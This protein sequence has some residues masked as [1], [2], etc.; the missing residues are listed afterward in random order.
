MPFVPF[1]PFVAILTAI[2]AIAAP[3]PIFAHQ[4]EDAPATGVEIGTLFGLSRFSQGPTTII[5]VPGSLLPLQGIPSLYISWFPSEQLAIGPE[6]SFGVLNIDYDGFDESVSSSVS[7]LYLG[8]RGAFFLKSNAESSPYLLVNGALLAISDKSNSHHSFAAG[9][10]LGHQWRLGPA[11]V[12]RM[13]G[14]YRRWSAETDE[15]NFENE[16]SLLLGLGIRLGGK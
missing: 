5:G 1:V 8:G 12:L 3:S 15:L 16:F 9:A 11:F 4:K 2:M 6:F 10:G 14:R 7:S 13:E